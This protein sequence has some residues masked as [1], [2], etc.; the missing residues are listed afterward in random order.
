[1]R[2]VAGAV[3]RPLEIA[4]HEAQSG[5]AALVAIRSRRFDLVLIDFTLPDISGLDLIV[6]LKKER[7]FVPWLLMSD[8]MPTSIAVKAMRLGAVDVL[9][10]PFDIA[11]VVTTALR[12]LPPRRYEVEWPNVPSA[13]QLG[14][15]RSAAERWAFLVLRGCAAEHD[16][17]T[18]K[19]WASDVGISYSALTESCRLIGIRPHDARDLLRMLRV[20][21]RSNGLL[22]DLEHGLDV[23]DHRTLKTLM[24]RAGLQGDRQDKT[25]SLR[26]FIDRQ[27]FVDPEC[28]AMRLMMKTL[29]HMDR[30]RRDHSF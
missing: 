20:L 8:Q 21:F 13:S 19:D 25:I 16:L 17:K 12:D 24:A 15:P 2:A 22:K 28:E 29:D 14:S 11:R 3:L 23:N 30:V 27:Q 4:V 5:A 18:I 1:M 9:E 7:L 26:E 10:Q 6:E